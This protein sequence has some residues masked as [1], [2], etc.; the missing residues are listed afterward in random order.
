G[1]R[2][3]GNRV[4]W[5]R[6]PR[7]HR[8]ARNLRLPPA[9][10]VGGRRAAA[11]GRAVGPLPLCPRLIGE[12]QAL[13]DHAVE[14]EV[15][16]DVLVLGALAGMEAETPVAPQQDPVDD[17]AQDVLHGFLEIGGRDR[18]GRDQHLAYA[19][20]GAVLLPGKHLLQRLGLQDAAMDQNLSG[21]DR[22]RAG[23]R[24]HR[25]PALEVD[26]GALPAALQLEAPMG[27]GELEELEHL[28][29]KEVLEVAIERGAHR[30][31]QRTSP[32]TRPSSSMW[33]VIIRR[34]YQ[35]SAATWPT[36]A[37]SRMP[38]AFS[39]SGARRSA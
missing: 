25:T 35:P 33:P 18:A 24:E 7:A 12:A 23:A 26:L 19:L 14:I 34:L 27:L 29:R 37:T 10:R 11:R 5:P 2:T 3:G 32:T 22:G 21:L 31:P 15:E 9:V 16:P 4:G 8:S 17:A 30:A 6:P 20:A 38:S 1:R 39:V 13:E 28:P 36:V